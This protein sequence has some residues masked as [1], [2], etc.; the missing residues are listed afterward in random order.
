MTSA[1]RVGSYPELIVLPP[2]T[3]CALRDL[4]G[5]RSYR[6]GL[7]TPARHTKLERMLEETH[8]LAELLGL[9]WRLSEEAL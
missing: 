8:L 7:A 6:R 4:C 5:S 3:L 1:G 9:D 2:V